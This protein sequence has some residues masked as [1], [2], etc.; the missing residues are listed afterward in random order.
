M[1]IYQEKIKQIKVLL[2][3]EKD[4]MKLAE[5]ILED[6]VTVVR[7]EEFKPGMKIFV[8]SESGEE[9]PAPEGVHTTQDGVKVEVDSEGTIVS[10]EEPAPTEDIEVEAAEEEVMITEEIVEA[11]I[12]KKIEEMMGAVMMVVEE[13][14]KEVSS[15]KEEM[16]GYKSKME[17]M[18]KTPG[19]TKTPTFNKDA[20]SEAVS[21]FQLQLEAIEKLRAVNAAKKRKIN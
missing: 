16:A 5:A 1:N 20:G 3:L 2:G 13:V 19:S 4:E 6:G 18:S 14:A 7:A 17:K 8:V 11:I 15:I 21:P 9:A 10:V 12:E